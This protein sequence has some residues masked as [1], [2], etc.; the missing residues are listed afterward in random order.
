M[1]YDFKRII[2]FIGILIMCFTFTVG[3]DESKTAEEEVS[4]PVQ[5]EKVSSEQDEKV[6]L[7]IEGSGVEEEG[8]IS[9]RELK[10]MKD[11]LVDDDYFSLNSYG[12]KEY[13]H[14][15]GIGLNDIFEQTIK[16]KEEAST[17]T[18]IAEDGYEIEYSMEEAKREDYIDEQDPEKKYKMIIAWEENGKK[19]DVKDG[20]P[21][22]LVVGQKEEGDLNKPNW[23][24]H[25][26]T[27]QI[28]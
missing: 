21:F 23:V 17:V 25:L 9:L 6:F 28:D 13:F 15:K 19:Y 10:D 7:Y 2:L 27:I 20:S 14:F 4:A 11:A 12:T 3:C 24:Q 16:L 5:E 8:S 22:R 26:K 1:T 18:F